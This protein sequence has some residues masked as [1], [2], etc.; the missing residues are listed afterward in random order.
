MC[1][2]SPW[3]S[4]ICTLISLAENIEHL[5]FWVFSE[6]KH[7]NVHRVLSVKERK[8][9]DFLAVTLVCSANIRLNA[10]HMMT[11]G[12]LYRKCTP[13]FC[14]TLVFSII[15]GSQSIRQHMRMLDLSW[16][17]MI[18]NVS[19]LNIEVVGVLMCCFCL[20]TDW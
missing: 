12:P 17:L 11:T 19:A 16:E 6:T 20:A 9:S 15:L 4:Y 5:T 1:W 3:C 2:N 10:W 13:S 18:F 14:A 8:T 7:Q